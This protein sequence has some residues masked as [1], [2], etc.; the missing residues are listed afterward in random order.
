MAALK[1][2]LLTASPEVCIV[3][4]T[5]LVEGNDIAQGAFVFKNAYEL[6]PA[7]TL[8]IIGVGSFHE[9]ESELLLI[10]RP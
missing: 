3:D 1:G 10:K 6:F 9:S 8:H 7:G 5:H 2:K 4:I